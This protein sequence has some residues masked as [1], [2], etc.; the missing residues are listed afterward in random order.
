MDILL[1]LLL[2]PLLLNWLLGM[3]GE[4]RWW[5]GKLMELRRSRPLSLRWLWGPRHLLRHRNRPSR[6]LQRLLR[7]RLL[8]T[9]SSHV[10]VVVLLLLLH[11]VSLLLHGWLL[12]LLLLHLLLSL[13]LL[14]PVLLLEQDLLLLQ[15]LLDVLLLLLLLLLQ[16]LLL[17][18]QLLLV[19]GRLLGILRLLRWLLLVQGLLLL[20]LLQLLLP[21]LV[22]GRLWGILRL[23]RWLL[24]MQGLLLLLLLLLQLLVLGRR[25]GILRLL[26]WLLLMQ[27]LL[28]LLLLPVLLLLSFEL[29]LLQLLLGLQQLPPA[30]HQRLASFPF[31][32]RLHIAEGLRAVAA[33]AGRPWCRRMLR[34]DAAGSGRSLTAAALWCWLGLL[35]LLVQLPLGNRGVGQQLRG[36]CLQIATRAPNDNERNRG[37]K[38][39]SGNN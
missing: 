30:L 13:R 16:L 12:G 22:L 7:I 10:L 37:W 1:V 32:L 18:L 9:P 4:L 36:I 26:R 29:T 17:L 31:L 14:L 21:L 24:L 11:P 6:L 3:V 8:R 34:R 33:A 39:L 20:L 25:R 28:L 19:L 5:L 38:Q 2:S 27:G 35:G 15:I 23:L